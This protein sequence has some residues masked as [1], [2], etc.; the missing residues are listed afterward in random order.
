MY[1]PDADFK[2]GGQLIFP[3]PWDSLPFALLDRVE[4]LEDFEI[5]FPEYI[6]H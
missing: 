5:V 2:L 6:V 3:G 1:E 4:L